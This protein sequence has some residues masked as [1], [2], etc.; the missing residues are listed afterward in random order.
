M[1]TGSQSEPG[2]QGLDAAQSW[3]WT[4]VL[5]NKHQNPLEKLCMMDNAHCR[6]NLLSITERKNG[7]N[8]N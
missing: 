5:S 1:V 8:L 2:V 3:L 7:H 6:E 4:S